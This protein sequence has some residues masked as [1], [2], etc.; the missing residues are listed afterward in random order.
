MVSIIPEMKKQI[1]LNIENLLF[2]IAIF[3]DILYYVIILC[4]LIMYI[5]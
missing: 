2:F 3:N 4:Q 5:I 1:F